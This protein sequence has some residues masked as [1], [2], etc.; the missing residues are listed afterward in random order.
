MSKPMRI[1]VVEDIMINREF[2][3]MLMEQRGECVCV[4]S[5]EEA[6]TVFAEALK[7]GNPFDVVF[8]DIM[9]PGI[10]GHQVLEKF[11]EL[12]DKAGVDR[13]DEAHVIVTTAI[14]DDASASRA[15]I[16][17]RAVSYITK[18]VREDKIDEELRSLGLTG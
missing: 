11:R 13:G 14:D 10:N 3:K 1:L 18:P 16:H 7:Q 15:F 17:G 2:L 4:E 8:L 12:E 9:L 6:V 5:G